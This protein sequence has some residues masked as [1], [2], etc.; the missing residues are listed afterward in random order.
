RARASQSRDAGANRADARRCAPMRRRRV[1]VGAAAVIAA[2]AL[3]FVAWIFVYFAPIDGFERTS[4]S[5]ITVYPR[6]GLGDVIIGGLPLEGSGDVRVVVFVWRDRRTKP[7]LGVRPPME[8]RL[9]SALGTRI[10]ID[11]SG[12]PIPQG[13]P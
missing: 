5:S 3:A 11:A 13:A 1:A 9:R 12:D 10:V 4:A 8:M 6:M 2:A 7:L